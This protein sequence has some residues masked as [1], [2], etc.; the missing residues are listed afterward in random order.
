MRQK[1]NLGVR[2]FASYF[3]RALGVS[4]VSRFGSL[5][6]SG[7]HACLSQQRDACVGELLQLCLRS[8]FSRNPLVLWR[9]CPRGQCMGGPS[10][11]VL[12]NSFHRSAG[13]P[14]QWQNHLCR[15]EPGLTT[16]RRKKWKRKMAGLWYDLAFHFSAPFYICLL[17]HDRGLCDE[18]TFCC[19]LIVE[20]GTWACNGNAM[21][22]VSDKSQWLN[23]YCLLIIIA[24][25][26]RVVMYTL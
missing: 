3:Q 24:P 2:C 11:L 13:L 25:W 23:D 21:L 4:H 16:A 18:T 9:N 26:W 15:S 7:G 19:S 17:R 6:L 1:K 10:S 20:K 5:H 22:D 12:R 8:R 14:R